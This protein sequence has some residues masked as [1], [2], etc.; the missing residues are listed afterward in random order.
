MVVCALFEPFVLW[1]AAWQHPSLKDRALV[2]L[3]KNRI[4]H[5]SS[6]ARRA[7][8]AR[9]LTL[10]GARSRCSDLVVVEMDAVTL[11]SRWQD[12][13]SQLC[14]FTHFIESPRPGVAFLELAEPDAKEIATLFEA[15]VAAGP[16]HEEA[17]LQ[18]LMTR[19]GEA[20]LKRRS[21][22]TFPL[23]ILCALGVVEKTLERLRWVGVNGF[24]DLLTWTKNQLL[25]YL[26]EEAALIIRYLHGPFTKTV[27]RFTPP[28]VL[29]S[30]YSFD[31]RVYEPFQLGPVLTLLAKRLEARL[32]TNVASRLSLKAISQG[33][34]FSATKVSRNPLKQSSIIKLL[35]Q[36][37][38]DETGIQPL[39]IEGLELSLSGLYRFS[40][41]GT[42][43][44]KPLVDKAVDKVNER[45]PG[46]LLKI[47]E[48]NTFIPDSDSP[49][50][51]VP[52]QGSLH[53]TQGERTLVRKSKTKEA[54]VAF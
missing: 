46:A 42:L 5:A 52:I 36:T 9:G 12:I 8:I 30:S 11:N 41:Q 53:T 48:V 19:T 6:V 18:S 35:A 3:E 40:Q 1:D 22:A 2:A 32:E 15:R 34:S 21:L 20:R 45:Y 23:N 38:L 24:G 27:R 44:S 29:T 39:G 54:V 37:A 50:R 4:L 47:E 31:E 28:V 16:N 33:I 17:R 43:W 25:D 13:L 14:A 26:G 10:D 7:G 49:F 51:L